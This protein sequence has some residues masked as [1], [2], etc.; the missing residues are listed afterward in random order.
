[1]KTH[2]LCKMC[3]HSIDHVL[4]VAGTRENI[5]KTSEIDAVYECGVINGKGW[6]TCQYGHG[7][8]SKLAIA[9]HSN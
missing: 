3:G 4:A 1:M 8:S 6:C 2:I 9:P 7:R 5:N